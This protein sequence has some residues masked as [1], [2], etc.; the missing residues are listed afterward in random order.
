[1]NTAAKGGA[2]AAI[3]TIVC[4][5]V[6]LGAGVFAAMPTTVLS[7]DWKS[8]AEVGTVFP[9]SWEFFTRD[10]S[11]IALV[12]YDD[13]SARRGEILAEGTLPQTNIQNG[14]G[15]SRNQRSQ[16]TEKAIL[17]SR[18][19]DWVECGGMVSV[20]CLKAAAH[21]STQVV[22]PSKGSP[23]FCGSYVIAEQSPVPYAYR[24][25]TNETIQVTKAA[26]IE[27]S[28]AR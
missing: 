22:T 26:H 7:E 27:I 11:S 19:S 14:L 10:P 6:P 21:E 15:L 18:T 3:A 25:V 20:D 12:V 2:I 5:C 9:E 28:C 4:L 13:T 1:M 8:R 24:N 17:A 23:N 16:D